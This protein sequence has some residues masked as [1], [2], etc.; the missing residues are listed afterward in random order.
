MKALIKVLIWIAWISSAIAVAFV[1]IVNYS[2]SLDN[3]LTK[4]S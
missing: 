4:L 2:P 1:I 3:L